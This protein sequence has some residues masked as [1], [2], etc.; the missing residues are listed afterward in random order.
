M[1]KLMLYFLIGLIWSIIY[2]LF[3]IKDCLK[4]RQLR[5]VDWEIIILIT[6]LFISN[7]ILWP[8]GMFKNL[9]LLKQKLC[10]EKEEKGE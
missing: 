8:V 5:P 4:R 1:S 9:Q 7:F 3:F 2:I 6:L 10:E